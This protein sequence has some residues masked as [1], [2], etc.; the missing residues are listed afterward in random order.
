[1]R[2][3]GA[4]GRDVPGVLVAHDFRFNGWGDKYEP[5]PQDDAAGAAIARAA[6]V[7]GPDIVRHEH[8][9]EGGALDTDGAGTLD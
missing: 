9:L 8:V 5:R 3:V 4:D 6:G 7:R 2:A 1:M